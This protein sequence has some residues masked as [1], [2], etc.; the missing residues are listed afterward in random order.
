MRSGHFVAIFRSRSHLRPASGAERGFQLQTLR[1][2]VCR[3]PLREDSLKGRE[4]FVFAEDRGPAISPI[5]HMIQ[6]ARF[7]GSR[8]SWHAKSLT[9]AAEQINES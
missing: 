8:R 7:I 5:Q 9:D 6:P 1:T 4:I 2:L 3:S